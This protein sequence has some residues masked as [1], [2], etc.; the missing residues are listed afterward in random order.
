MTHKQPDLKH[1]FMHILI[2]AL[3]WFLA[4]IVF[5][6][7]L[8]LD[9]TAPQ[10]NHHE[11]T[12]YHGHQGLKHWEDA[13]WF[14]LKIILLITENHN[15]TL[16]R[17]INYSRQIKLLFSAEA[18]TITLQV[19]GC[20]WSTSRG[21]NNLMFCLFS[22]LYMSGETHLWPFLDE[23]EGINEPCSRRYKHNP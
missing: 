9:K 19:A 22:T 8:A 18:T 13:L 17:T 12:I 4:L 6:K 16:H 5:F 2:L 3:L 20:M 1:I 14:T 23:N 10:D 15:A 11:E 7:N 21:Q